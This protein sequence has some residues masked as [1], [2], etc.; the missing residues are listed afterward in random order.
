LDAL[1]AANSGKANKVMQMLSF[2]NTVINAV[3]WQRQGHS[4]IRIWTFRN[5]WHLVSLGSQ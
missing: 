4:C 1:I 2:V 3:V 5:S